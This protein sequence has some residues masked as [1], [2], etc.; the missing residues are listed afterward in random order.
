MGG[1]RGRGKT[2]GKPKKTSAPP[3][4]SR[5]AIAIDPP[6]LVRY[7]SLKPFGC[8]IEMPPNPALGNLT[9]QPSTAARSVNMSWEK[10]MVN[11]VTKK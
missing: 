1:K 9:V 10:I 5:E 2:Y 8:C 11:L 3:H 7:T 4:S 6:G